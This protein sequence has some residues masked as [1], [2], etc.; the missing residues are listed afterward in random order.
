MLDT[1]EV[2]ALLSKLCIGLGFCLPPTAERE[3]IAKPPD[4]VD[5]FTR[6]V[7]RL[8]G[9]D[10]DVVDR[11]LFREVRNYV[12]AAFESHDWN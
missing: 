1:R 9:L 6:E 10:P 12:A 11:H 7:F 5:E 8:E 3:L 2:E 4:T